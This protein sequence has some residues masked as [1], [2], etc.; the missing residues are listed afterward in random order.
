M[1]AKI[2]LRRYYKTWPRLQELP[3]VVQLTT[4]HHKRRTRTFS[5]LVM[6]S[7]LSTLR[8]LPKE[9][10]SEICP[11]DPAGMKGS[12][13]GATRFKEPLGGCP[14]HRRGAP[15]RELKL[16]RGGCK[17]CRETVSSETSV[18]PY[19]SH[20]PPSV[21]V[22]PRVAHPPPNANFKTSCPLPNVGTRLLPSDRRMFTQRSCKRS[23]I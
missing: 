14:Y 2:L 19:L 21:H 12:N 10:Q 17:M 11:G 20:P 3:L 15:T 5:A 9:Q 22:R 13:Q 16:Q 8:V 1:R 7:K 6:L 23:W 4:C 18:K